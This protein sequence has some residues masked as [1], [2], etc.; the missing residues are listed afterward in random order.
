MTV[1]RASLLL[2]FCALL[3]FFLP[4]P[5]RCDAAQTP[6]PDAATITIDESQ[7]PIISLSANHARVS[8]VLTQLSN[9]LGFEIEHL[10]IDNN[11]TVT[12]NL[13]GELGDVLR[14]DALGR[15]NF[16]LIGEGTHLE[17]LVFIDPEPRTMTAMGGDAAA[18]AGTPTS[19]AM[20]A[21]SLPPAA[22]T[23]AGPTPMAAA[24]AATSGKVSRLLRAQV[25]LGSTPSASST[26]SA[27]AAS[28]YPS[29]AATAAAATAG[30]TAMGNATRMALSNVSS[31]SAALRSV[32]VGPACSR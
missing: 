18:P 16:L 26:G 17:R 10:P 3:A 9:Q 21:A 5:A 11:Q 13:H 8:D 28:S 27:V 2:L 24:L 23:S 1:C 29:A 7:L 30:D 25:A 19:S 15:L 4:R 20:P 6:S 12:T 31:L 14:S 32:C 22:A